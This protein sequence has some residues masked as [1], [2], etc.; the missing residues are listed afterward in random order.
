LV[1]FKGVFCMRFKFKA[2]VLATALSASFSMNASAD[3]AT[4]SNGE[5]VFTVYT[6]LDGKETSWALDTGVT[7]SAFN[8]GVLTSTPYTFNT[9]ANYTSWYA[10]LDAGQKSSLQWNLMAVDTVGTQNYLTTM[11]STIVGVTSNA[12]QTNDLTRTFGTTFGGFAAGFNSAFAGSNTADNGSVVAASKTANGFA[13]TLNGNWAGNLKFG[14]SAADIGTDLNLYNIQASATGT[15]P[16]VWSQ[17]ANS[18]NSYTASFDGATFQ[19]A[20]V[21]E[22]ETSA[23][24]LAGIGLIGVIVRR[25]KLV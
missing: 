6:L 13:G 7:L 12:A 20:A 15:A 24:L 17:I 9:D 25:R 2:L 19:V 11:T 10:G 18:G 14:N 23:M 5:L 8:A 3:L 21:P 4:G 22:A 16:S 1:I